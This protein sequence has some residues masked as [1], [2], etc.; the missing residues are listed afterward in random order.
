MGRNAAA[1]GAI[2]RA[3]V[4]RHSAEERRHLEEEPRT[5][6]APPHGRVAPQTAP[7]DSA[8]VAAP[9]SAATPPVCSWPAPRAPVRRLRSF[10]HPPRGR[11]GPRRRAWQPVLPR[12]SEE[13]YALAALH[14]E[15]EDASLLR[16]PETAMQ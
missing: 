16:R 7:G 11:E 15:L 13:S 14:L 6:M 4:A 3:E 5:E 8:E 10:Q 2:D 12:R 1:S 9:P